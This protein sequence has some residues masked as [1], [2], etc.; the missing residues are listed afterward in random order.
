VSSSWLDEESVGDLMA[1]TR[2]ERGVSQ[3]A[4]AEALR[5]ASGNACATRDYV[6]RWENGKRI[7]TPYWR[8][9]LSVVLD[10]PRERIDRSC[11]TALARR[12]QTAA[13]PH[14]ARDKVAEQRP[15]IEPA[16]RSGMAVYV[17]ATTNDHNDFRPSSA[18][19]GVADGS[20]EVTHLPELTELRRA[21]DA[22]DLP[23]DGPV[24]PIAEL[25]NVLA[26]V[27]RMRLESRYRQLVAIL[28]VLLPELNRAMDRHV[29]Q[30]RT[31]IAD[32]LVQAFRA[33]DA[34][35]DKF[36][37]FDLSA[38]IIGLMTLTAREVNDELALAT[39]SY[40]RAET[41]FANGDFDTGRRMLEQAAERVLPGS[42]R[43][44]AAAYGALHMRAAVLAARAGLKD[45]AYD[46]ASEASE[47]AKRVPE[48][49]YHGTVFGPSSVRIH[50]VTLA[51]DVGDPDA[52]LRAA[53]RWAP[54]ADVPAERRSHFYIDLSRAHAQVGSPEPSLAA[55]TEA[56]RIA[57]E[58]V[59]VHPDVRHLLEMLHAGG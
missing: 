51:L 21:L 11:A 33:A 6:R 43:D 8:R 4:L 44:A 39:A 58:H 30:R 25:Q 20:G 54:P 45:R 36:S 34:L 48:G 40:V 57:P 26:D 22:Y 31:I 3:Y 13:D 27:V 15:A 52:A 35:A 47:I 14:P 16:A 17:S 24:R 32:F 53:E 37:L 2:T 38:R 1:R 49:I 12:S 56:R 18:I 46:H 5:E 10:V 42:S 7:P 59:R 19:H 9:Y 29:G 55:L 50:E 41:F 28:P 23:D